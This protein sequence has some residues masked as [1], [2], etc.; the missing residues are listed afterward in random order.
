MTDYL[1]RPGDGRRLLFA[2][3]VQDWLPQTMPGRLALLH[4]LG[5][6]GR[7]PDVWRRALFGDA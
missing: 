2:V 6:G 5:R 3:S 1:T 4:V 7:V